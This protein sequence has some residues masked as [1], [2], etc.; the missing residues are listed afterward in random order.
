MVL[1]ASIG[2]RAVDSPPEPALSAKTGNPDRFSVGSASPS[3]N[4]L[5]W[6]I[7][8]TAL[9]AT[10]WLLTGRAPF[11]KLWKQ[12]CRTEPANLLPAIR[13]QVRLAWK[14]IQAEKSAEA[15]YHFLR[16]AVRCRLPAN[17]RALY[18]FAGR[19]PTGGYMERAFSNGCLKGEL[20]IR[21]AIEFRQA[22]FREGGGNW[23]R[24]M[25]LPVELR[26]LTAFQAAFGLVRMVPTSAS[27]KEAQA[28]FRTLGP[29]RH[30]LAPFFEPFFRGYRTNLSRPVMIAG[31]ETIDAVQWPCLA[32]LARLSEAAGVL[33]KRVTFRNREKLKRVDFAAQAALLKRFLAGGDGAAVNAHLGRMRSH[34][35]PTGREDLV[36][37]IDAAVAEV[38]KGFGL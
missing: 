22:A 19:F 6:T 10:T 33:W 38:T 2:P 7:S 35:G 26:H 4:P 31:A 21:E 18:G 1:I 9:L 29:E 12:L 15:G 36:A 14:T 13:E 25:E 17:E 27:M 8:C 30:P 5:V 23:A 3:S 28:V 32:E 11:S 34:A 20:L 37:A 24:I 16:A